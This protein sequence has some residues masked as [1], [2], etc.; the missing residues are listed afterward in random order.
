[1]AMWNKQDHEGT[2]LD[3]ESFEGEIARIAQET[4]ELKRTRNLHVSKPLYRGQRDANWHLLTTLDRQEPGMTLN[5][6]LT[7]MEQIRPRIE[8]VSRMKWPDL[9]REIAG[10]R[11]NGLDSIW[12]FP[13]KSASTETIL[14]FMTYLRQH[15]FPSP[16]L[17]WT[18]DPYTA[19]FFAFS[20]VAADTQKVAI[21]V[22]R[23]RV[24]LGTE[25]KEEREACATG[26]GPCIENTS[27]RH[28]KQQAQYTWCVKKSM[29]GKCLDYYVFSDHEQVVNLPGFH[30]EGD[31]CVDTDEAGNPLITENVIRKYTI[32]VSEQRRALASLAQRNINKRT[33]FGGTPDDLLEDLWNELVADSTV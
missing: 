17:D 18:S 6:Y 27:E 23:E 14:S 1:M 9:N 11:R 22:F 30:E 31:N 21:Y 26:I 29:S 5:E 8:H 28:A 2:V 24:G 25:A 16:L 19:A 33:L 3:W 15:G 7:I 13:G 12:L 4:H 20:G 32:P 10:Q